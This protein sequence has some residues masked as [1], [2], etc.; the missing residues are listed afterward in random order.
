MTQ[1]S[2]TVRNK[3]P[4]GRFLLIGWQVHAT[5]VFLYNAVITSKVQYGLE[6]PEPT[7]SATRLLNVFPL[8]GLRKIIR[9]HTTYMPECPWILCRKLKS[10]TE[11]LDK[12]KLRLL[13]HVLRRERQHPLQ[14]STFSTASAILRGTSYNQY[15]GKGTEWEIIR[16]EDASLPHYCR[17]FLINQTVTWGKW[18]LNTLLITD[19]HSATRKNYKHLSLNVSI[20]EWKTLFGVNNPSQCELP[21]AVWT[22]ILSVNEEVFSTSCIR[23]SHSGRSQ[24]IWLGKEAG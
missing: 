22:Q 10:L 15:H 20:L 7:E 11:I 21:I 16:R 5:S 17:I 19:Y 9:L 6:T 23:K 14:Q 4:I 24:Q 2:C 13:G 1:Q 12:K 18:L 8:R 3:G